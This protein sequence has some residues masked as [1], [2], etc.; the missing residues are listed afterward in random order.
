[1]TDDRPQPDPRLIL[2]AKQTANRPT[3]RQLAWA[4]LKN[5]MRAEYLSLKYSI[6]LADLMK[7]VA[8]L[9]AER[10]K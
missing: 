7:G 2:L 8:K 5:G 6:P 9:E 10:K 1:M 3:R 4:E